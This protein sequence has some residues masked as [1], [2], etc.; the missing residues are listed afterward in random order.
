MHASCLMS[1]YF[2]HLHSPWDAVHGHHHERR[3]HGHQDRGVDENGVVNGLNIFQIVFII[4][5]LNS[6]YKILLKLILFQEL[7]F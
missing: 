4:W 3:K 6:Q 1:S 5:D 7:T 2:A